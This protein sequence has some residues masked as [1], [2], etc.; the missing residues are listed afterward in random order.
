MIV[1]ALVIAGAIGAMARFWLDS[2]I[3]ARWSSAM[4]WGTWFINVTGS[5]LL[6]VLAGLVINAG[7]PAEVQAV[8]GTGFCGGYTTFSTASFETVRLIEKR[9][10]RAS[11]LYASA[12]VV[13]A[14]G[15]CGGGLA[16]TYLL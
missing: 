14:A 4:P 5:L 9:Q 16:K 1:V 2:E 11:L 15:A 3:K 10:L 13:A 8:I 7:M 6:G 12:S